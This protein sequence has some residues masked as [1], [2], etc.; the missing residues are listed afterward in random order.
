MILLTGGAGYIGS[1]TAVRLL[2]AGYDVAVADNFSNSRPDVVARIGKITG[3]TARLHEIDVADKPELMKVFASDRIDA[4]IHFA[5]YKA[6][7]ESVVYPVQYYRNNLDTTLSLLEAMSEYNV[8]RLIFSSSATVYGA[9]DFVPIPE[10]A[11]TGRCTN[12]YGWGKYFIE[13]M[14]HD[15]AK[16]TLGMSVVILRYF[17]PVG[18]HESGL[19][20]EQPNGVPNNLMPYITQTAAGIRDKLYI[21]G[22]DYP[23]HD[24]TGIRDYIHVVD[25]ADGHIAALKYAALHNGIEAFN[26]GTGKGYSVLDVVR[27]FEQSTGIKI[28]FEFAPRREGDV[29]VC[30][31]CVDK[32]NKVLSWQA[33]KSLSD[34]CVDA[35]R[36]QR[37]GAMC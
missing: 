25:L 20:G 17:N 14:L 8:K 10:T 3:K 16:A 15:A 31:A 4:V 35:W 34:M 1:H 11:A 21:F 28:P 18:A 22:S 19:L 32:A 5:G 6:I 33:R 30:Y 26:L 7:G 36:W 2:E 9:P 13:Q 12:P 29:P 23:T 27:A 37:L 24:G